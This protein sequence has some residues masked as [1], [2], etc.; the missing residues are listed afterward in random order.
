M[1]FLWL[2]HSD[3]WPWGL[4]AVVYGLGAVLT[5]IAK[6]KSALTEQN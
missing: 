6:R 5:A 3:A 4:A 1:L 2:R